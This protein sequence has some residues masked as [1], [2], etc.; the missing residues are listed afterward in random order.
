MSYQTAIVYWIIQ[1]LNI[2]KWCAKNSFVDCTQTIVSSY[3]HDVITT[4]FISVLEYKGTILDWRYHQYFSKKCT[5]ITI[6]FSSVIIFK[7]LILSSMQWFLLSGVNTDITTRTLTGVSQCFLITYVI[8]KI[9]NT[10]SFTFWPELFTHNILH[11]S[12]WLYYNMFSPTNFGQ[13]KGTMC[14]SK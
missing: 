7:T 2:F 13:H 3:G 6:P 4:P 8:T 9:L 14:I 12:N 1:N 5:L 11:T 10:H